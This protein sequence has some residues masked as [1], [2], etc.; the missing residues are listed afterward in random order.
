LTVNAARLPF[1]NHGELTA[2]DGILNAAIFCGGSYC[3]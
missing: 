3:R 2:K 1:S